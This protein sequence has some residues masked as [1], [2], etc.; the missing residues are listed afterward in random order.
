MEIENERDHPIVK[1][2]VIPCGK[3]FVFKNKYFMKT[4][5]VPLIISDKINCINLDNG[6]FE[7]LDFYEPVE[8]INAKL[9]V[10]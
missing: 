4:A 7:Y 5:A 3:V 1:F 2:A 10:S 9:V 6:Q 8:L